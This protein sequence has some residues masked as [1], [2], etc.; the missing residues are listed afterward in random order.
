MAI[1]WVLYRRG[2]PATFSELRDLTGINPTSLSKRL[3]ILEAE[4]FV[5]RHPLNVMPRRVEYS[6]TAMTRA[7][8]PV[9]R[10]LSKWRIAFPRPARLRRK[11]P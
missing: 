3:K 1:L 6:V 7:S 4:G 11:R 9:W 2:S 10:E 5:E 8:G